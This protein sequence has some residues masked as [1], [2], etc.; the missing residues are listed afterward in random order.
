M[1]TNKN[2]SRETHTT[3]DTQPNQPKAGLKAKSAAETQETEATHKPHP[4]SGAALPPRPK[5]M[6]AAR[7]SLSK[8]LGVAVAAGHGFSGKEGERVGEWRLFVF[9]DDPGLAVPQRHAGIPVTVRPVPHA[10]LSQPAWGK[11]AGES[12]T[13]AK[14]AAKERLA[15]AEVTAKEST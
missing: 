2:S 14:E 13:A 10:Q 7:E 5:G 12:K 9:T 4:S 1:A 8:K 11:A 3:I 6:D 15:H